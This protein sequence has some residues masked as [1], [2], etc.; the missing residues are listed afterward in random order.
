MSGGLL[1][2]LRHEISE[3]VTVEALF[4]EYATMAELEELPGV[5]GNAG[6]FVPQDSLRQT[7]VG[8]VEI[9]RRGGTLYDRH[10]HRH[11][12]GVRIHAG[13]EDGLRTHYDG[14][15]LCKPW[16]AVGDGNRPEL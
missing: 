11:L 10:V 12:D 2:L 1:Y 3:E 5:Q 15:H 9:I 6:G 4:K 8:Q 14:E 16:Y 7:D 13:G